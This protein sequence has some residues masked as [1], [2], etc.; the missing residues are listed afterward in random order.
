ME[1]LCLLILYLLVSVISIFFLRKRMYVIISLVPCMMILSNILGSAKILSMPF[2]LSVP[3]GIIPYMVSFFL[4]DVLN[5]F[6]GE[7]RARE[8]VVAG[9]IAIGISVLLIII[10]WLWQPSIFTTEEKLVAFERVFSL[11]PRLFLASL[12]SFGVSSYLNIVIFKRIKNRTGMGF[13]WLR[14]NIST[15]TAIL[16][17]NLIFIPLGYFG[18]G[19]PMLNMILGHTVAQTA[20]ALLDTPFIY[21]I[22]HFYNKQVIDEI[23]NKIKEGSSFV[24]I[25]NNDIFES[26]EKGLKPFLDAID[27][28]EL[29]D[30]YMGDKFVGK[31]SALLA[32]YVQPSHIY[33]SS[34]T[35]E[36]LKILDRNKIRVSYNKEIA[37]LK[38]CKYDDLLGKTNISS[39]GEAYEKIR[40]YE[41][42]NKK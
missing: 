2:N 40:A 39:T 31:A 28:F 38:K 4:I 11:A 35:R 3:A 42:K 12:L 24:A 41:M 29:K 1:I 10:V 32:S 30:A 8:G 37:M 27:K 15:I 14:E 16:A 33:A 18:T 36:A 17:S 26:K 22:S 13:L 19:Y 5:E 23:E 34:I 21:I 9:I 7:K 25:K 20:V 6:Y